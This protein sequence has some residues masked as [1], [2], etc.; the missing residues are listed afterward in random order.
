MQE[1]VSRLEKGQSQMTS[2]LHLHTAYYKHSTK[3]Q[4]NLGTYVVGTWVGFTDLHT[5]SCITSND[6]I[7]IVEP[8]NNSVELSI[9]SVEPRIY[10]VESSI[11]G[12]S[13]GREPRWRLNAFFMKCRHTWSFPGLPAR[14]CGKEGRN[15][16]IDTARE[17][18]KGKP[19]DGERRT[20]EIRR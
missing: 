1:V 13:E 20:V 2:A 6:D 14:Y 4:L 7:E 5:S 9:Y 18:P 17:A 10:S 15:R 8:G 16:N 19:G 3:R 12:R 11:E